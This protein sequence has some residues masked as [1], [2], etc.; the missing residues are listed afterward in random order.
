MKFISEEVT[1]ADREIGRRGV[2]AG[3]LRRFWEGPNPEPP[4]LVIGT[5][6]SSTR[7]TAGGLNTVTVVLPTVSGLF[8]VRVSLQGIVGG[9]IFGRG[10]MHA[11]VVCVCSLIIVPG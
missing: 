9:G 3:V 6:Y 5:E 4:R 2:L 11:I 7:C 1:G 8:T 10:A